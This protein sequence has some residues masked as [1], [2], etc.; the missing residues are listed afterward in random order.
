MK[1][2]KVINSY[3]IPLFNVHSDASNLGITCVFNVKG[4]KNICYRNLTHL[5]KSF[6]STWREIVAIPFS[7]LSSIKQFENK[8]IIFVQTISQRN[9]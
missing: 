7:L 9:K 2:N 3:N 5:G 8:C 6:S 4:K 1:Y